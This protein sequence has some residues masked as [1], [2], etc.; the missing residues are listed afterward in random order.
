MTATTIEP[1]SPVT[2]LAIMMRA[3]K[4][5]SFARYAEEIAQTHVSPFWIGMKAVS[6]SRTAPR[7]ALPSP[8]AGAGQRADEA[9][10]RQRHL[11]AREPGV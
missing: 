7:R 8:V 11:R 5:P 2:S 6:R 1:P 9:G 3:L 10:E 4:L